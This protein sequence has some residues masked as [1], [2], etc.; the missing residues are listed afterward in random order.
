MANSVGGK[1]AS[2][3]NGTSKSSDFI[4]Y[5]STQGILGNFFLHNQVMQAIYHTISLNIMFYIP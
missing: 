4:D 3:K 2:N 5:V 1:K